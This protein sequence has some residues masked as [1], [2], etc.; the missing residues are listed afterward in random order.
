MQ[1]VEREDTLE[2]EIREQF[3]NKRTWRQKYFPSQYLDNW[4][5]NKR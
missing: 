4:E 1:D 5:E 2:I 3:L